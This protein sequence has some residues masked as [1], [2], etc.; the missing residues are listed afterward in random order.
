[1]D[2]SIDHFSSGGPNDRT[3]PGNLGKVIV[4]MPAYNAERTLKRTVDDLPHDLIQ[5]AILV[6][7]ASRDQTVTLAKSLGLTVISHSKNLGYGANIKRCFTEALKRSPDYI[8]E[9]HPDYQ[10][11]PR[12]IPLSVGFLKL[13]TCNVIL[14]SRIRTRQEALEGGMPHY[15]Y[16]SNLFLTKVENLLLGQ[17]LS[18]AHTGFRAYRRE[19]LETVPFQRNSDDFI[20]ATQILAQCVYFGFRIGEVPIQV[21]YFDEASS[22]NFTRSTVY[23]LRTLQTMGQYWLHRLGLIR[24]PLFIRGT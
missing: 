2:R 3:S 22:I 9:L 15:K 5:E 17:Q 21:R 24:S 8:V 7:D 1:M 14:G 18:D 19:V 4:V 12:V 13:G 23:G 11:D 16:F 10:Y 6:D 20:F